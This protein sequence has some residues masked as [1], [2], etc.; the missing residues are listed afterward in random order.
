MTKNLAESWQSRVKHRGLVEAQWL[1]LK[2]WTRRLQGSP[3]SF[4]EP[5]STNAS[6][7]DDFDHGALIDE[8]HQHF[9][10]RLQADPFFRSL[11]TRLQFRFFIHSASTDQ[12]RHGKAIGKLIGGS[13][14]NE[15]MLRR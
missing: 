11:P 15:L 8:S 2:V 10:D 12:T 13:H 4:P 9:I 6:D 3:Y 14:L 5:L 7:E 1:T